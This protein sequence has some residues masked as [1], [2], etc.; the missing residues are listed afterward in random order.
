M[1]C[2]IYKWPSNN[3]TF[4]NLTYQTMYDKKITLRVGASYNFRFS[5]CLGN[6]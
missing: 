4:H 5:K 2:I 3:L 6:I 1:K